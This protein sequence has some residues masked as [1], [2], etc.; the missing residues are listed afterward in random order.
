MSFSTLREQVID[1]GLCT[2]CGSCAGIC[3]KQAVSFEEPLGDCLPV[4][5]PAVCAGCDAP[6]LTACPGRY[7]D[8]PGLN[9]ALF[10]GP[11]EDYLL[12]HAEEIA[13]GY[14][15][16]DAIRAAAA[17]GGVITG[18]LKH[19]LESGSIDGVACLIDDPAQ[20]LQPRPVI[21]TDWETL[22]QSQQSK[23][24]LTPVNTILSEIASFDGRIAYV[25][26]PDQV[27]SIRKLQQAGDPTALKI[28]LVIGSFCGA[29]NH[30]SSVREFLRKQGID[31]LG[32]VARIEYRAGHWPGKMRITLT[33]GRQLELEKFYAN[34]M[35]LFYVVKRSLYCIDLSN[36][37]ADISAGDAWAPRYEDRHE[38]FSIII[39]RTG[40]GRAALAQCQQ[41]GAIEL[42]PTDRADALEMHSHGLYNKKIAVWTRIDLRRKTGGTVPDYG[43]RP[44]LGLRSR[45]VGL[46]IAL[47]Y[48]IGQQ[49]WARW[50]VNRLPIGITGRA[51]S[52]MRKLW[53]K[54]TRPKR[55]GALANYQIIETGHTGSD[56]H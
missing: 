55:T 43:Y 20:P 42:L 26:L 1:A 46:W 21:C 15:T 14:S 13:V 41:A 31:D 32:Q 49:G 54:N 30:F 40:T 28:Q 23:Y 2:R 7:V 3:P 45:V 9:Q 19:L 52:A 11:P 37:L 34:Y 33:D 5:D 12:G 38:G 51:F 6:C 17:S 22:Q 18:M 25:G 8:F 4:A 36:E 50:V 27:Q 39:G 10:G 24:S 56:R 29:V 44:L 47:V 35:N 53:R 16:D 48:L